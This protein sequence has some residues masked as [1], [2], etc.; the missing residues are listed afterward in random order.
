MAGAGSPVKAFPVV[1]QRFSNR[2]GRESAGFAARPSPREL[3]GRR[4]C[5]IPAGVGAPVG[6]GSRWCVRPGLGL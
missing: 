6:V 1:E 5:P 4:G 2:L 3:P